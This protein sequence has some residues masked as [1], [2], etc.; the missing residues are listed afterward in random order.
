MDLLLD[1][2][3]F[4]WWDS[5]GG[6]SSAAAAALHNPDNRLHLSHASLWEMQLKHQKGKLR[7]RKPLGEIIEDQC[8]QNRLCMLAIESA[9]IYGLSQLAFHHSDPFDRLII[10][11]ARLRGFAVVTDDGEFAK[12]GVPIVW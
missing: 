4:I 3:A 8:R 6:L 7:L 5:G 1:T 12:Y 2:C 9:D 10:S 11:Q